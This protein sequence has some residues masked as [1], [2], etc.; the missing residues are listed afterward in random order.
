[1]THLD[2]QHLLLQDL[3]QKIA[4]DNDEEAVN[5]PQYS[6]SQ[7]GSAVTIMIGLDDKRK[8]DMSVISYDRDKVLVYIKNHKSRS[9]EQYEYVFA[10][11]E[12]L[13][14]NKNVYNSPKNYLQMLIR[15]F[16]ERNEH[17][18]VVKG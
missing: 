14:N 5:A 7:D 13:K 9:M 4:L 11:E 6:V 8:G 18:K 16:K 1:M 10:T 3:S 2:I 12:M 15:E 17:I